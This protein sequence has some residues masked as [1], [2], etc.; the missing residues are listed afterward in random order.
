M[1]SNFNLEALQK[2]MKEIP[3]VQETPKYF[4]CDREGYILMRAL[5]DAEIKLVSSASFIAP[6]HLG[7][8][9]WQKP[10]QLRRCWAFSNITTAMAYLQGDITEAELAR[11]AG[12]GF[13]T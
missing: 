4:V 9:L 2:A 8:N 5:V 13:A 11:M 10:D 6:E 7:I 1:T 12:E 3:V